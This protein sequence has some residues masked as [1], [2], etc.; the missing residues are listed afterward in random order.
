MQHTDVFLINI[1]GIYLGVCRDSSVGIATRYG[2]EGPRIQ[3]R[4]RKDFPHPSRPATLGP[5]QP[6]IKWVPGLFRGSGVKHPPQ[7]SARVKEAVELYLY[8]LA[9]PSCLVLRW[10]L[11]VREKATV[12]MSNIQRASHS[13]GATHTAKEVLAVQPWR[14]ITKR[15]G[16]EVLCLTAKFVGQFVAFPMQ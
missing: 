9:G 7:S 4:W 10:N 5:I 13:R 2:L 3:S 6:C 8:S 11:H 15:D 1:L 16:K 14:E 12:I